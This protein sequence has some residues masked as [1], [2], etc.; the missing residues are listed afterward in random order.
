MTSEARETYRAAITT[1]T[2]QNSVTAGST[3]TGTPA[4]LDNTSTTAG[5]AT[6]I[7]LWL[8][9]GTAPTTAGPAEIY[10]QGSID[11]STWA[12]PVLVGQVLSVGTSAALWDAGIVTKVPP[13]ARFTFKNTGTATFSAQVVAVPALIVG[14]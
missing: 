14:S 13:H 1:P 5:C 2:A 6:E 9:V 11:G 7:Q 8:S 4:D 10:M 12:Q 3:S